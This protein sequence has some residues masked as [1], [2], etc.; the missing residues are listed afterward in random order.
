MISKEDIYRIIS[1]RKHT[2]KVERIYNLV[3]IILIISN[4]LVTIIESNKV[5]FE[6]YYYYFQYF[7][8]FSVIIFTAEY[9]L[10]LY[11]I[12]CNPKFS[13]FINSRVKFIFSPEGLIDLLSFLPFYVPIFGIT[14][15]RIIRVFRL[16]RFIRLFK[17]GRYSKSVFIISQILKNKREELVLTIVFAV[18]LIIISSHIIFLLESDVQ[19]DKYSDLF[20][21]MYWSVVTLTSVGY[22]DVYPITF[23][24]KLFTMFVSV[25]GLG[26]VALPA[27]IIAS[28]FNELLQKKECPHCGKLIK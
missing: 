21:A 20:D 14:D 15:L 11:S 2:T 4:L 27:G 10:R 24:G 17:I 5:T 23:L 12:T 25:I 3:M 13:S 1:Y 19:P 9:L 26:L 16:F 22:G 7:E 28:G 8:L 6:N 18:F